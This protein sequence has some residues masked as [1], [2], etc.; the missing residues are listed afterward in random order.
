MSKQAKKLPL[1]ETHPEL[2]KEADGWNPSEI[3]KG[4]RK[5]LPWICSKN[6]RW[7][8]TVSNRT[9]RKSNCP[10]CAGKQVLVGFNDL[11]TTHP[12]V[13]VEADGWDPTKYSAGSNKKMLWKCKYSHNWFARIQ[14]RSRGNNCPYCAGR[15]LL[16][17]FN[18]LA[19][20]H[21]ELAEQ[22]HG[23]DPSN[24]LDGGNYRL[25]WKCSYGHIWNAVLY[26]R[27]SS[28]AGCPVCSG[29]KL[30]IGFNDLATTHPDL[31]SQADNWDPRLVQKGSR[32]KRSWVCSEGHR[33][34][35]SP[36]S[37]TNMSAGCPSCANSGFN[38]NLEA[39]LYFL[40]Q[41]SWEMYQIGITNDI[42]RRLNEHS[43]NGWQLIDVRGPID[44]YFAI[45]WENSI[46]KMLKAKGADLSNANVAGKFDGYTEAWSKVTFEVN[47]IRE[48]MRLTDEFDS[49]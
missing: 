6:H 45:Q 26:S 47:S 32:T 44:G 22:A 27:I 16:T 5:K 25:T 49:L 4:S 30:L 8:A 35:N 41:T 17:G 36:N 46:L 15:K 9:S 23:W 42:S 31:A 3:T 33:W 24:M 38:P 11:V 7:L 28:K 20:R 10:Y 19:T 43:R 13:A 12:L 21:P 37:R 29:H 40:H 48:L 2:A 34:K 39:Y 18:D 1:L 14:D